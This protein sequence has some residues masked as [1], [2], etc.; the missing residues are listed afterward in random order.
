MSNDALD[1]RRQYE[2]KTQW[3]RNGKMEIVN[4]FASCFQWNFLKLISAIR[5]AWHSLLASY[6]FAVAGADELNHL[7]Q[8]C[9]AIVH[10]NIAV[11]QLIFTLNMIYRKLWK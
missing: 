5:F 6:I 7:L 4:S 8:C 1:V 10:T 2:R 11:L 3:K 9:C